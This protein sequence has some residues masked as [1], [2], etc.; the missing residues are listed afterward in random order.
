MKTINVLLVLCLTIIISACSNDNET[1]DKYPI[2][3]WTIQSPE[4]HPNS[5]TAVVAIPEHINTYSQDNDMVA[6]FINGECRGVGNLVSDKNDRKR[7]YYITVRASDTENG[8]IEFKYYNSRL[9]YLYRAKSMVTFES[10]A[11]YGNYDNPIIL[12]L[13]QI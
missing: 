12:D 11:T 2:P 6:A 5:F 8:N 1:F 10:D 9:Q 4:S 7:V 13:E 3:D